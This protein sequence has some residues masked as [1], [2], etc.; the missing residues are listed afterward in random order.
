MVGASARLPASLDGAVAG[1]G[2]ERL[3]RDRLP[4]GHRR[5][6]DLVVRDTGGAES[7]ATVVQAHRSL[8]PQIAPGTAQAQVAREPPSAL[9]DRVGSEQAHDREIESVG[10]H[11]EVDRRVAEVAAWAL[12]G[13]ID[14]ERAG[15]V[16]AAG[17]GLG[18]RA[19]HRQQAIAVAPRDR[20][21]RRRRLLER[22]AVRTRREGQDRAGGGAGQLHRAVRGP[23]AREPAQR[24]QRAEVDVRPFERRV[25]RAARTGATGDGDALGVRRQL[26]P[27][28]EERTGAVGQRGGPRERPRAVVGNGRA[29]LWQIR[30]DV[31]GQRA[32]PG[33]PAEQPAAVLRVPV[34]PEGRPDDAAGAL[35]VGRHGAGPG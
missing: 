26:E 6:L 35:H 7:Q 18:H 5:D 29:Q 22:D 31:A 16:E 28:H 9:P 12:P 23:G 19:V 15:E 27:I 2:S 17:L 11:R 10:L 4:A 21:R 1:V 34:E 30:L 14:R 25:G 24:A 20:Q 8:G 33:R 13:E 3:D 32:P